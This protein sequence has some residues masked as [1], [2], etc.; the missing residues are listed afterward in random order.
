MLIWLIGVALL[1]VI[2]GTLWRSQPKL[3]FGILIGLPV[4][5]LIS[6]FFIPYIKS[7]P[8]I[9][10]WLAPLPVVTV[11]LTL[12]VFGVLIWTRA[13]RLPPPRERAGDHGEEP[14]GPDGH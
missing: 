1:V 4:A 11:A 13:D 3:A 6:T 9:P 2:W 14:H 7:L 8:K 5:W 10:L 12:F